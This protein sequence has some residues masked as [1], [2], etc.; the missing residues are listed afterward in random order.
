MNTAKYKPRIGLALGS[1]SARGWSHIGVI[2][3]LNELGIKPDV[4]CGTSIGAIIAASYAAGNLDKLETWV[5][6]LTRVQLSRYFEINLSLNGFVDRERLQ[7]FFAENICAEDRCIEDLDV[8]FGAVS[9]NLETGKEVWFDKGCVLDSVWAS[10]A[11]PALFPPVRY[12]KK[13]LVDGGLV[14][15]VPISVCRALDADIVIA[16]NLSGDIVGKHFIKSK[17]AGDADMEPAEQDDTNM[18]SRIRKNIAEYST[19]LFGNHSDENKAPGALDAISGSVHIAM[20]RI[21]RSRMAGDPPDVLLLPRLSHIGLL[22]FYRG[23]EA[24]EEGKKC[25][26]RLEEEIRYITGKN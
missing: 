5:A 6:S 15:P 22:E 1:G 14:N 4:V 23:T 20:D 21:T 24:I 25:V 11:L 8:A 17:M 26:K 19:S 16:V 13:W 12:D 3:A 9:T 10:I 18:I 2:R 7:Q